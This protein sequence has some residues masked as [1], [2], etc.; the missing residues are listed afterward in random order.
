MAATI[1]GYEGGMLWLVAVLLLLTV[2]LAGALLA[3]V[4]RDPATTRTA[5]PRAGRTPA[6]AR[7]Q[8]SGLPAARRR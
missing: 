4:R 3:A 5:V 2:G 7:L 1:I 8:P 6:T